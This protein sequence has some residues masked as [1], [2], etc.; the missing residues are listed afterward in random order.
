MRPCRLLSR[1]LLALA[2]LGNAAAAQ[3]IDEHFDFPVDY[4]NNTTL[5]AGVTLHNSPD[6]YRD[7]AALFDKL[8]A[9]RPRAAGEP[10]HKANLAWMTNPAADRLDFSIT[11]GKG[12]SVLD[13]IRTLVARR[14]E[15]LTDKRNYL[16][17]TPA[18]APRVRK[19]YLGNPSNEDRP[20]DRLADTLMTTQATLIQPDADGT[21]HFINV[22]LQETARLFYN[23]KND[24]A[25][26]F[27]MD[28]GAR[29]AMARVNL[30][31]WWCY[32]DLFDAICALT[33]LEWRIDKN[34]FLLEKSR[35]PK[36]ALPQE[37]KTRFPGV[38]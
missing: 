27:K 20:L 14:K 30:T 34:T 16:V 33:G 19:T 1:A 8:E 18:G 24:G 17:I 23:G 13:I 15:T 22:K 10:P 29:A 36:Q 3:G 5:T 21:E 4:L 31:G 37:F 32:G 11:A 26:H 12:M 9:T 6:I 38:P 2:V 35:E 7:V 28:A 25:F